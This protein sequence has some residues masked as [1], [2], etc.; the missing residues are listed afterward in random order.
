VDADDVADELYALPPD[1][2]IAARREREAQARAAGDRDLAK[3]IAGLAKPSSAAWVCNLLAREEREEI[4]GLVELGGMLREAQENLAGDELRALDV[5][6]RR[7]VAALARQGRALAHAHGHPVSTAVA[8]Q[9]EE[10]LRAAL[11]DP[12]AAGALAEGRLTTALSYSGLGTGD[13]PSLRV[14]RPKEPAA[15]APK[16]GGRTP[17]GG[18]ASAAARRRDQEEAERRAAEEQRRRELDQA[19]RVA[20]EAA[21]AAE[22]AHDAQVAEESRVARLRTQEE[23]LRARVEELSGELARLRDECTRA[24]AE[25]SRAERRQKTAARRAADAVAALERAR[26]HVEALEAGS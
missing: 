16:P 8:D 15:K 21:A 9:V 22:E 26:A 25:L 4:E 1:E 11:A 7:L 2:F 23:Q 3:E 17:K 18:S 20:D 10:T 5:Q 13:R 6:R 19:R 14:V 24:E 12:D